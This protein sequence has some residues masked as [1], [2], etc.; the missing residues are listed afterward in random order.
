MFLAGMPQT[1]RMDKGNLVCAH[2]VNRFC[3][4]TPLRSP[5]TIWNR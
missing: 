2:G 5:A 4:T 1:S 3:T